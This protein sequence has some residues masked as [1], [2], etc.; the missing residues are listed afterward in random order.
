MLHG[1]DRRLD[2][3]RAGDENHGEVRIT[4]LRSLQ[5][6]HA[7]H[8]GQVDVGNDRVVGVGEQQIHRF[9]AVFGRVDREADGSESACIG[10]QQQRVI[11]GNQNTGAGQRGS[12]LLGRRFISH[13]HS[14]SSEVHGSGKSNARAERRGQGAGRIPLEFCGERGPGCRMP[15]TPGGERG[16]NSDAP[17]TRRASLRTLSPLC[18]LRGARRDPFPSPRVRAGR[19]LG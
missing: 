13:G 12:S 10:A 5:H 7:V 2:T 16:R 15:V 1:R 14:G 19:G 3:R 18:S 4:P 8:A 6:A 11:L 17:L 9:L